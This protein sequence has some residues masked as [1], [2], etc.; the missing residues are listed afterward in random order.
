MYSRNATK[1]VHQLGIS[2]LKD[3][4]NFGNSINTICRK[5]LRAKTH[6]LLLSL[7]DN[8]VTIHDLEGQ[9]FF[10]I[11]NGR[12]KKIDEI[13]S[14]QFRTLINPPLN[15]LS[16]DRIVAD[17]ITEALMIGNINRIKG[18][19]HKNSLLRIWNGD[20]LSND[21]LYHMGIT[22][23]SKC[24]FCD[25][26]E[27]PEHRLILCIRAKEIWRSLEARTGSPVTDFK[28]LF[29]LEFN[30]KLRTLKLELI[31]SLLNDNSSTHGLLLDK[32]ERYISALNKHSK[33][34][35]ELQLD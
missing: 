14:K 2:T 29:E 1:L 21:R 11:Q 6:R 5:V 34:S 18:I 9:E 19:R 13:T 22:E 16:C 23:S 4:V 26:K 27:T 7:W 24:N 3:A 12:I 33:F 25:T 32:S 20:V 10:P 35:D 15:R 31:S 30:F 17:Q 28:D 8:G